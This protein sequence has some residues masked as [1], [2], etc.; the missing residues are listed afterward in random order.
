MTSPALQTHSQNFINL[1]CNPSSI[2]CRD[3]TVVLGEVT[4]GSECVIHPGVTIQARKGP[5]SIGDRNL[6]EERVKIINDRIEPMII[7]NNNVFEV[8]SVCEATK[9]GNENVMEAKSRVGPN[10]EITS[11]CIIGAGCNLSISDESSKQ[12]SELLQPYTVISGENL[13]RKV[14]DT[15]PKSSLDSQLDFLR[16]VLPNYQKL[17]RQGNQPSTPQQK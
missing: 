8:D 16:K 15:L 14:V 9:V 10:I 11:N 12:P 1:K 3:K 17:W 7:G 2:I 4:I 13:I 5:I 6:I